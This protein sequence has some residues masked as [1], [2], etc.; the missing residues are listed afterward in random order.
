M[1]SEFAEL[2][3]PNDN[4]V[5]SVR[6]IY[7]GTWV[8]IAPDIWDALGSKKFLGVKNKTVR[9]NQL[10]GLDANPGVAKSVVEVWVHKKDL[11]R[12]CKLPDISHR[13]CVLPAD[14]RKNARENPDDTPVH[15]GDSK[16]H[17]EWFRKNSDTN[18]PWTRL[19][20]TYDWA[21]GAQEWDHVGLSEFLIAPRAKVDIHAVYDSVSDYQQSKPSR[22][23]SP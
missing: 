3:T 4:G 17:D 7:G 19:G 1:P 22:T 14:D 2:W 6:D 20:F 16:T 15:K 8:T 11:V 21:R 9:L 23:Y 18:L 13:R 5:F 12:P 10:L